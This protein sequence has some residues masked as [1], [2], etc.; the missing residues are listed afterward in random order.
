MSR[1]ILIRNAVI[2][3][4]AR[5]APLRGGDILLRDGKIAAIGKDLAVSGDAQM[6]DASRRIAIPGFVN[7]HM[8]S[9]EAFE[10]G[11][12]VILPL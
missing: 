7:A 3:A 8:H 6:I 9:N 12:F 2:V 10:Q 1:S 4:D 5:T 11:A